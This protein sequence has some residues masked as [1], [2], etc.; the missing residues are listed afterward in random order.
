MTPTHD[1]PPPPRD[2]RDAVLI[3]LGLWQLQRLDW[4]EAS[5]P[6]SRRASAPLRRLPD[7]PRSD[8]DRYLPVAARG[9]LHGRGAPRPR[10]HPRPGRG[11]PHRRGLRDS[12]TAAASWSTKAMSGDGGDPPPRP[13]RRRDRH[14]QPPLARRGRPLDARARPGG[15]ALLRP[16]RPAMAAALGTEPVLIVARAVEGTAPRATA[17]AGRHAKASRTTTSA[18]RSSGSASP[19]LGGDDRLPALAY[20]AAARLKGTMMRYVSTRGQAPV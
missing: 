17:D 4:K 19:R 13:G 7:A 18:T 15:G 5:S 12:T 8:R 1:L 16:R 9:D 3:S 2:R 6:R 10:L 11:L 14:R 20:Q